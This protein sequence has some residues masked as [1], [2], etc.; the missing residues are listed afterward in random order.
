MP[1]DVFVTGG[2]YSSG[3]TTFGN[4]T[5][6]T[7]AVSGF[8]N[9]FTGGT[10]NGATIFTGGLT[11]T[12]ISATTFYGDGSNLTNLPPVSALTLTTIVHNGSGTLIPKGS[13]VK[14][15]SATAGIPNITLAIAS[16]ITNNEVVGVAVNDIADGSTGPILNNGLLSGLTINTFSVGDIIY[17]SDVTPGG[18]IASTSSLSYGS[19]INQIGYITNTG[20]TTGALYVNINNEQFVHLALTKLEKD[21]TLGNTISTGAYDFSGLTTASTTTINIAPVRAWVVDNTYSNATD[22]KV[23]NLQYAGQTGFSITNIASQD[24]TYILL[25]TG[26]TIT[27]QATYPTPVQRRQN[28]FLGKVIHPNRSTIQVINNL[29]DYDVSPMSSL[30]DMFVPMK[31]INDGVTVSSNGA[32]LNFNTSAGDFYGMGINWVVNQLSPNKVS[33]LAKSPANFQYKTMT[34]GTTGFVTLINPTKYDLN[35]VI[36]TISAIGDGTAKHSTN[37]RIYMYPT[38]TINVQYGQ[39]VYN[40]LALALAGQQ[41]ESFT[42]TANVRETGILIG[43]LAVRRASTDLSD[44]SQA[45]FTPASMFG[46]SVGGVNGIS[47]TTLQQAYNN[48][49]TPEITINSTLD[50]LSIKNGT[51]NADNITNLLEGINSTGATTSFIRADGYISGTTFQTNSFI[52]NNGGLTATTISATTISATTITSPSLFGYAIQGGASSFNPGDSTTYYMGVPYS[53]VPSTGAA[54]AKTFLPEAG[55]I[56]KVYLNIKN[57]AGT[58]ELISYYI[59]VNNTTDYLV[60]S[61]ATL[62][63]ASQFFSNT[64]MSV[65]VAAGDYMELKMVCPAWATNPLAVSNSFT[66]Y[67]E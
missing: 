13:A 45:I 31:L 11:A 15:Q 42:K 17:L 52:A 67:I 25:N 3:T 19:R 37:Q 28:I 36:T 39:Q 14:I 65:T 24:S 32:N 55:T 46:E 2:T 12:T 44:T 34:G 38:G 48:S 23:T 49:T 9:P 53:T 51:G 7:F 41:T 47:T 43:L 8:T 60:T 50:G 29:V 22:P 57:T 35:G 56:K 30:R 27:Q 33:L 64:A 1:K 5:G 58:G 10:V 40:D 62:S 26:G 6:G 63:A 66:L 21:I 16:G 59:R 61:A 4:S 54:L 20:S 18:F